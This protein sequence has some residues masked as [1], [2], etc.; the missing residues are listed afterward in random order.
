MRTSTQGRHVDS[1]LSW[2]T[3]HCTVPRREEPSATT[4][5][6]KRGVSASASASACAIGQHHW[7]GHD[8]DLPPR[9]VAPVEAA[10]LAELDEEHEG[11]EEEEGEEDDV[12]GGPCGV[13]PRHVPRLHVAILEAQQRQRRQPRPQ[14]RLQLAAAAAAVAAA[15]GCHG[16]RRHQRRRR[17]HRRRRG[18]C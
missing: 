9:G 4:S 17:R 7:Q 14:R 11:G 6:A 15:G 18:R 5:T 10:L 2:N 12:D 8:E 13:Q 3:C 16:Q 1:R